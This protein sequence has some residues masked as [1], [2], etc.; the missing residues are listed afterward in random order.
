MSAII[1][2]A[3]RIQKSLGLP[4]AAGYLRNRQVSVEA[5]V[6]ILLCRD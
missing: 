4:R 6:Y 5:A 1:K 2:E 3:K